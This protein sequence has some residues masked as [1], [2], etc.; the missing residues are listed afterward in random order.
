MNM[1][2]P[3]LLAAYEDEIDVEYSQFLVKDEGMAWLTDSNL[4]APEPPLAADELLRTGVDWICVGSNAQDHTAHARLESWRGEPGRQ[5]GWELTEDFDFTAT[6]GRLLLDTLTT[7]PAS[8]D[9][10]LTLPSPGRYRGR[11]YSRGR[12]DARQALAETFDV[13]DG[14][15]TYLIQFWGA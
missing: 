11:A 1:D 6:S 14:T 2:N 10:R 4:A 12:A 13:P 15:E 3:A 9:E 5:D 8:V 7:G